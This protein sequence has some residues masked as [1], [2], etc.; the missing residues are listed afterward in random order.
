MREKWM[1][2]SA[3]LSLSDRRPRAGG[4]TPGASSWPRA[5]VVG[6]PVAGYDRRM[7]PVARRWPTARGA[8]ASMPVS[9]ITTPPASSIR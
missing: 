6:V 2:C 3:L 1:S 5:P 9:N 8:I 4:S 7:L